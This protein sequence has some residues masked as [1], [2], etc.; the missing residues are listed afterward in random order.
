MTAEVWVNQ[1]PRFLF[2][3]QPL[4]C[5]VALVDVFEADQQFPC[6]QSTHHLDKPNIWTN[7]FCNPKFPTYRY[8][9]RGVTITI[10]VAIWDTV[11]KQEWVWGKMQC[12]WSEKKIRIRI[13]LRIRQIIKKIR[14]VRTVLIYNFRN[15][16]TFILSLNGV[17]TN[18]KLIFHWNIPTKKVKQS[19]FFV[20]WFNIFKFYLFGVFLSK[21]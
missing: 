2:W 11:R 3:I 14:T 13:L 8:P 15:I 9:N 21:N 4:V 5:R 1:K 16:F 18:I 7:R 17:G 20:L 10:K 12:C 19:G 6:C